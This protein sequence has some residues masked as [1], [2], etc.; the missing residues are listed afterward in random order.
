MP[1]GFDKEI[2]LDQEYPAATY[3]PGQ[4]I[5][6]C[7]VKDIPKPDTL[8]NDGKRKAL[9]VAFKDD[10]VVILTDYPPGLRIGDKVNV[11]LVKITKSHSKKKMG[12]GSARIE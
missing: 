4:T 12:F 8:T 9:P 3:V 10:F 7:T 11:V 5:V 2:D 6:G 1:E